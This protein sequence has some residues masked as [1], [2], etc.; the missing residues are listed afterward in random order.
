[1]THGH[2]PEYQAQAL[3]AVTRPQEFPAG[4]E[5]L[6]QTVPEQKI[7]PAADTINDLQS[8]GIFS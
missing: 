2:H 7:T 6:A 3:L 8:L 1:M 4:P 5:T